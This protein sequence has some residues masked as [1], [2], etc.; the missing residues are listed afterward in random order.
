MKNYLAPSLAVASMFSLLIPLASARSYGTAHLDYSDVNSR[1][2][3][4]VSISLLTEEGI[5]QG[6]P[7]GTFRP[8]NTLNRAEFMEIVMNA[9]DDDLPAVT[10]DCFPDVASTVWYAEPVCHAKTLGYVRGNVVAGVPAS[11]WKFEPNRPVQYAEA[12]KVLVKLFGLSA[13]ENANIWYEPFI[14]RAE[15]EGLDIPGLRPGDRITRGEMARLTAAFV[16]HAHGELDL[17]RE[18][19]DR[20]ESGTS[21]SSSSRSSSSS[22]SSVSSRSSSSSSSSSSSRSSDPISDT[23]TRSNFLVLGE[24]GS[25]VASGKV[26]ISQEGLNVTDIVVNLMSAAP[27]LDALYVYGEDRTFLGIASKRTDTEYRLRVSNS[28]LI[29][30]KNDEWS[31]YVRAKTTSTANGGLS[32]QNIQ[33]SNLRVE[34]TGV[35]SNSN[36]TKT[37]TDTF[38]VF[39]TSRSRITSVT[40]NGLATDVL[41]SGSQRPI[42]SFKF[43]GVRADNSATLR[44]PTLKFQVSQAGGASVSNVMLGRADSSDRH[45]CSISGSE[46]T[47]SSIPASFGEFTDE[48]VLTLYA[49]VTLNNPT[50]TAAIIVTLNSAG[51]NT[52]AGSVTWT[53]GTS[54]FSW[55]PVDDPVATGTGY[56]Y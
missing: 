5:V 35:D 10:R 56:R 48:L 24:Q 50:S 17:L 4:A 7:D 46:I 41:V 42:G 40:R 45:A 27:S 34:G 1:S 47:C 26:F 53:D 55:L 49:D 23:S 37:T 14:A 36:Y 11:M 21:S 43:T 44:I 52:T 32:G 15:T 20:A 30:P 3:A 6:N 38:P 28:S 51:S 22:S 2:N 39:T 54:T 31:F 12:V 19:E 25:I 16:A 13:N 18:A 33:V 8:Q 9:Q 29:V